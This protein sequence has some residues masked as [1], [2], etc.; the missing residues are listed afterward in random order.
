MNSVKSFMPLVNR[1][2][3]DLMEPI[4]DGRLASDQ[5][6]FA[7]VNTHCATLRYLVELCKEHGINRAMPDAFEQLFQAAIRAGHGEDD[8]AVLNKFMS[9]P[10]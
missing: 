5:T 8:F 4:K 9:D 6:T 2:A 3:L 1:W 7:T 10:S